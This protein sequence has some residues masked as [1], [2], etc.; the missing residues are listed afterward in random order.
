MKVYMLRRQLSKF[1]S[2]V[3]G[4]KPDEFG[5]VLDPDGFVPVRTLLKAITEEKE[6]GFVREYHLH[7]I[8]QEEKSPSIEIA[9]NRIRATDRSLIPIHA[10]SSRPPKLLYVCIR[11]KAYS[12][13][14]EKGIFP[15]VHSQVVLAADK[16]L[17]LRLGKRRDPDPVLLTVLSYRCM[18]QGVRFYQAG[19]LIFTAEYIPPQC[20]TGPPLPAEKESL[21]RSSESVSPHPRLSGS[22]ILSVQDDKTFSQQKA[23]RRKKEIAW[24]K[25]RKRQI[26]KREYPN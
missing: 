11:K 18:E 21:P 8:L 15:S 26:Q 1:L 10:E 25:D 9:A 20:F 23:R 13:V 24:K 14:L 3:L 16:N 6:W 19:T 12:P 4:R 2:Y 22:Y 7:E 17:A 5:L